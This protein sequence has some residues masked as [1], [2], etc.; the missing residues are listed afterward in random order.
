MMDEEK[1][2]FVKLCA[3]VFEVIPKHLRG[4]FVKTWDE[5]YPDQKWQSNCASGDYLFSKLSESVK[6]NRRNNIYFTLLKTGNENTWD[7]RTL[8]FVMNYS[9]LQLIEE[10][11][12][13]DD[14]SV[15]LRVSE[16]IDKFRQI[17]YSFFSNE[18]SMSFSHD[19][20]EDVLTQI[21]DAAKNALSKDAEIEIDM[22]AESRFEMTPAAT[23]HEKVLHVQLAE[24]LSGI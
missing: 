14:R 4:L 18:C 22:I 20:F 11:R 3:I 16:E 6:K 17:R 1:G 23:V 12:N 24:D 10:C 5:R 7:I 13:K 9:G 2:N 19:R 15:P 21:K 8:V